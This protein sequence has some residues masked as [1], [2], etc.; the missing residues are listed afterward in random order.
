MFSVQL[1]IVVRYTIPII[2]AR[3]DAVTALYRTKLTWFSFCITVGT[4]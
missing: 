4:V 2:K 1:Y 3:K